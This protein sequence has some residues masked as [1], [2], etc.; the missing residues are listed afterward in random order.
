MLTRMPMRKIGVCGAHGTGKTTLITQLNQDLGLPLLTR[1]MRTMWENFG[2]ADFEKLPT[3]IRANFQKYA[4]LFQI[5]REEAAGSAGFI[6]DRTVLDNWAY[7]KLSSDM[8]Q[9][10]LAIYERLVRER[11]QH[12]THLIYLPVEFEVAPEPLRANINSRSQIARILEDC[13]A[14]WLKPTD[15]LVATGT[16]TERLTQV[17]TYLGQH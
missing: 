12:Y 3:D 16:L 7:T 17:R 10:D 9:A 4:L 6:T 2:V 11:L 1:T 8:S 13:L 15:Y 5:Q 14:S